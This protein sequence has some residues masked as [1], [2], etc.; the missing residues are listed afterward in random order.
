MRERGLAAD[1]VKR[2]VAA[3]S[4]GLVRD[5]VLLDLDKDED[6]ACSTDFNVVMNELGRFVEIQGA[7][8]EGDFDNAGLD[9]MLSAARKGLKRLFELQKTA[10]E[11]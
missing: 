5:A 7:A 1:P 6:Q 8:E 9:R 10:I 11:G 3:V 2:Q 4:V